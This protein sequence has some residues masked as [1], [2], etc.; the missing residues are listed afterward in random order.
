M[1]RRALCLV[2]VAAASLAAQSKPLIT[3]KDYGKW[4]LLGQPRLSPKG[5]WLAI[6]VNRVDEENEL[7]IKGGARDTTIVVKYG[8]GAVFSNDGKW[9]AYSIG[10]SPK[11]RDRLTRDKKPIRNSVEA[12]N[13]AS[14]KVVALKEISAFSFSPDGKFLSMTRYAAEGRR[15]SDVLVED[16]ANGTRMPFANVGEQAWADAGAKLALTFDADGGLGNGVQLYD[17]NAGTVRVL[18]SSSSQ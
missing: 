12:R 9:V 15:A 5:D 17:A 4:E 11:E 18:E 7:R 6:N 2:V 14:G 8:T 16:L 1:L 10:V 13:L 3:P